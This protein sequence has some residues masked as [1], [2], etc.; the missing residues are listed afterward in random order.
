MSEICL[1]QMSEICCLN[2]ELVRNVFKFDLILKITSSGIQ[3]CKNISKWNFYSKDINELV[4]HKKNEKLVFLWV[5]RE[6]ICVH[7]ALRLSLPLPDEKLLSWTSIGVYYNAFLHQKNWYLYTAT[8]HNN[9][10][11]ETKGNWCAG[12]YWCC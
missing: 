10:D 7:A 8:Q 6:R 2:F 1:L 11:V 4:F 9:L 3:I 12:R 5:E